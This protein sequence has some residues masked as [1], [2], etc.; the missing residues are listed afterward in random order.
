MKPSNHHIGEKVLTWCKE[1]SLN[2]KSER[3]VILSSLLKEGLFLF[4]KNLCYEIA[5]LDEQRSVTE[6][7]RRIK[8]Y[9]C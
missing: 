3:L 8:H 6:T 7:K 4:Y 5:K 9:G 2:N 1:I